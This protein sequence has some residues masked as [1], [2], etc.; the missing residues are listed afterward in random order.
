MT[1]KIRVN[2]G[3]VRGGPREGVEVS[4]YDLGD[5]VPRLSA[6]RLPKFKHLPSDLHFYHTSGKLGAGY[7]G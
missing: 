4:C 3:H 7:L 2:V 6:Q 1:Q 5:L